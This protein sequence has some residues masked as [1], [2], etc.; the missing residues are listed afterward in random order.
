MGHEIASMPTPSFSRSN[1]YDEYADVPNF[2]IGDTVRSA[3]FGEGEIIDIDG[4][5]VTVQ[6]VGGARKKLNIEYARLEKL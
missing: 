4:M 3:Q 1:D 6:F 2:D 5:A